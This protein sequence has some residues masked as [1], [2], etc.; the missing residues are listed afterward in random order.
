M[1]DW[2]LRKARLKEKFSKL[3][4]N[5]LVAIEGKQLELIDRL[6]KRLGITREAILKLLAEM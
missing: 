6:E 2:A 1:E 5:D 3:T 4:G